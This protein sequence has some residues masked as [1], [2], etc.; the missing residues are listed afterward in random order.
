MRTILL[1]SIITLIP[2]S[3]VA[4]PVVTADNAP[5]ILTRMTLTDTEFQDIIS[6][7]FTKERYQAGYCIG[8]LNGL[9]DTK[10]KHGR[11]FFNGIWNEDRKTRQAD[12]TYRPG[13]IST[14][15]TYK[16]KPYPFMRNPRM[17][18][19]T[20]V[21]RYAPEKQPAAVTDNRPLKRIDLKVQ[22][23]I[24]D[25]S[26]DKLADTL[27]YDETSHKKKIAAKSKR[28]RYTFARN[29]K[30]GLD[31]NSMS[32][33]FNTIGRSGEIRVNMAR[34]SDFTS[35][36]LYLT[37]DRGAVS[38]KAA[39]TLA[40]NAAA[41]VANKVW[42]KQVK[43]DRPP[44]QVGIIEVYTASRLGKTPTEDR[45]ETKFDIGKPFY[46]AIVH[47]PEM[48]GARTLFNICFK[49]SADA[50]ATSKKIMPNYT[51]HAKYSLKGDLVGQQMICLSGSGGVE[52]ETHSSSN[53]IP[54][55]KTL[56]KGLRV[57]YVKIPTDCSEVLNEFWRG[58]GQWE[59]QTSMS[60]YRGK[61]EDDTIELSTEK[62][63]LNLV[64]TPAFYKKHFKK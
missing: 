57:V 4:R 35:V 17:G 44:G 25:A 7:I 12:H 50:L 58:P 46:A 62:N 43:L 40:R 47:R 41:V 39:M 54:L 42:G 28:W 8:N 29:L 64:T 56:G 55:V 34:A 33:S 26:G 21:L 1:T 59:M 22:G 5:E 15:K 11:A 52:E 31:R 18:K 13:P 3:V 32:C 51:G 37:Y 48:P 9:G 19:I 10:Q 14:G 16:R 49:P 45:R 36:H 27:D 2:A 60:E 61:G 20:T 24:N 6:T 63:K 38:E 30:F 53:S 23:R